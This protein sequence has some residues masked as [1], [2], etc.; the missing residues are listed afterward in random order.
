VDLFRDGDDIYGV[1][2]RHDDGTEAVH[3]DAR[4]DRGDPRRHVVNATGAWAGNVGAMAG[5]EVEVRPS[6]GVMTIMNVRQVDTVIN[7]CRPK[8]DADIVVPHETTAILG[9]TDEEVSDPDDPGRGGEVDQMI[10]TLGTRPD[11]RKTRTVRS[12]WGVRPLYEAAGNRHR[13]PDRHHAGLLP[14]RPRRP[15]RRLG[16][17]S[18]VGGKFTTYRAMA[19]E[20]SDHVCDETRRDRRLYDRR[21]TP[22]RQREHRNARG[23]HGRLR[24]ALAGG[25]PEQATVGKPSA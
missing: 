16:M 18:I 5:V 14:A 10:E 3:R 13:G 25:P 11:P 8:G 1:E 4:D 23:R 6:K 24:T 12:F 2:V 9:T 7:R 22:A 15:R 17:S 21:G 19:E 20:I